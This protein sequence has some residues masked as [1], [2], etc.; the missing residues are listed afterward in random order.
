LHP[1]LSSVQRGADANKQITSVGGFEFVRL[2]RVGGL[3][4]V[5]DGLRHGRRIEY[6]KSPRELPAGQT[7][8]LCH[9]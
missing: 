9:L 5:H 3:R 4:P 1:R 7:C 8:V 2:P 6:R